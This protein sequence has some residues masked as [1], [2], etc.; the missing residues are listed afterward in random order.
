MNPGTSYPEGALAILLGGESGS[1]KTSTC[2]AFPNPWFIDFEGNMA[3]AIKLYP[4]KPW[5]FS[6]PARKGGDVHGDLLKPT[7]IWTNLIDIINLEASKPE[8]GTIVLDG[9]G[10]LSQCLKEWLIQTVSATG[11]KLPTIGNDKQMSLALWNPFADKLKKLITKLKSYHK[12]VVVTCHLKVDENEMTG[13]KQQYVQLQGQSVNDYPKNFSC[14]W[15]TQ[16][17]PS[18]DPKYA[19]SGGVR[20][21]IRNA[22]T[23][24]LQLKALPGLPAEFEV[25]DPAFQALVKAACGTSSAPA[26]EVA[27]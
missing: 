17:L 25:T 4:G 24:R 26:G 1:G 3:G 5:T 19:K 22:P 12:P 18:T 8:V 27:K 15:Q 13:V 16:A 21:F 2:M 10:N 20:Y 9:L 11:E 14:F 6:D 7:E 23:N